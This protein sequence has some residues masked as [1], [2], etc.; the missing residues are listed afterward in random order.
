MR[1]ILDNNILFSLMNPKSSSSYL[2]SL[3]K[4][5]FLAPEFIKSEF[6]KYR[7]S[8][9]SKSSL[10]EDEFEMRL[11]SIESS[12][13]FSKVSEYESFLKKAENKLSD[14]DDADFLALAI[15][16]NELVQMLLKGEI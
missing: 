10:S 5:E 9:I 11:S 4:A 13:K 2:F 7:K 6:D 15:S 3:I 8:C 1:L 14:P 12:I 16:T